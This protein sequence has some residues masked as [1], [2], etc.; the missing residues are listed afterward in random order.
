MAFKGVNNVMM[1]AVVEKMPSV[2]APAERGESIVIPGRDG[3]VWRGEGVCEDVLIP[4]QLWITPRPDLGEVREWLSGEGLLRLG[5]DV[6]AWQARVSEP[7]TY[8]PCAFNDGW[9]VTTTFECQPYRLAP[10]TDIAV[11]NQPFTIRNIYS[12]PARPLIELRLTGAATI[13]FCGTSFSLSGLTGKV[14]IDAELLECYTG[15]GLAN[16]HMTGAF[17]AIP[18]GESE[19]SWTGGVSA[20]TVRPRWRLL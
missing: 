10:A 3:E 1:G 14:W 6:N 9:K 4:V 16:D 13:S 17:P 7:G 8:V 15:S 19:I 12:R 2:P 20:M 18:P 5:A 11:A